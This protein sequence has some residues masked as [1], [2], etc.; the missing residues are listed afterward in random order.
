M[1]QGSRTPAEPQTALAARPR[2]DGAFQG[3][4]GRVTRHIPRREKRGT[5]IPENFPDISIKDPKEKKQ[6][7][8]YNRVYT[9][10]ATIWDKE[11]QQ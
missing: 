10:S 5:K 3:S 8:E 9:S 2:N 6:R 11:D 4:R 1:T 7:A